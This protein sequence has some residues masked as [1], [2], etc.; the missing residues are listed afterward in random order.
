MSLFLS[1]FY[2]IKQIL[3]ITFHRLYK[4]QKTKLVIQS[5]MEYIKSSCGGT[6][7]LYEGF[8]YQ[9]DRRGTND[10]IFWRCHDR[11][12]KGRLSTQNDQV[13]SSTPHNYPSNQVDNNTEQLKHVARENAKTSTEPVPAIFNDI[14]VHVA[15]YNDRDAMTTVLPTFSSYK[16]S[17]YR[18]RQKNY[19]ELPETASDVNLEGKWTDI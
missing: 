9:I 6:V 19:P 10:R 16:S 12:C 5:I 18:Q 4:G 7:L 14:V 8:R 17:L 13:L 15:Q 1:S 3:I 11:Q 2:Q